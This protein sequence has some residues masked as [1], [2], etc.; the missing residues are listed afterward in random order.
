[1]MSSNRKIGNSFEKDLLPN[2]WQ[3]MGSG[4][5]ILHRIA[6]AN[7]LTCLPLEMVLAIPLIVKSVLETYLRQSASKKTNFPL[8]RFGTRQEMAMAGL[9][10]D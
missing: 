8:C 5:T 2:V 10:L 7:R 3:R 4:Y 1:M 6:R 9:R